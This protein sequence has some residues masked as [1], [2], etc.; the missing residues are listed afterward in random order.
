MV[1]KCV[2]VK[3]TTGQHPGGI[4]IVPKEMEIFDFSP[5]NY[6]A[7]DKQQT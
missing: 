3:R 6:P 1:N 4:I 2:D 5:Y 7:D